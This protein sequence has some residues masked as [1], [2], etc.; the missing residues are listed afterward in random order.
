MFIN[1]LEV[2]NNT[3]VKI[4][5]YLEHTHY[6]Y[7]VMLKFIDIVYLKILKKKKCTYLHLYKDGDNP[8]IYM[9]LIC[10]KNYGKYK[11]LLIK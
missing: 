3:V 10:V 11:E 1:R 6:I 8:N 9:H 2:H 4:Q 7:T 5:T